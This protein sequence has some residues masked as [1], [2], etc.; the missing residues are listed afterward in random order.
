MIGAILLDYV[1]SSTVDKGRVRGDKAGP[2]HVQPMRHGKNLDLILG[3]IGNQW[4]VLSQ[5]VTRP[6]LQNKRLSLLLS[7]EQAKRGKAVRR[8]IT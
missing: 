5:S 1:I 6:D 4:R 8:N 3:I 2:D 7:G